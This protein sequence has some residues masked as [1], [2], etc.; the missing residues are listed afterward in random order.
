MTMLHDISTRFIQEDKP[1]DLFEQ[2]V[3]AA[4]HIVDGEMGNIQVLDAT[5]GQLRL[6]ACCS[7]GMAIPACCRQADKSQAACGLALRQA[8]RLVVDDVAA[9]VV[10]SATPWRDALLAAGVNAL[11]ATPLFTRAGKLVGMLSTHSRRR[12]ALGAHEQRL[13]DMLARQIA[14]IIERSL[15][16]AAL[17][18]SVDR[19]RS[20]FDNMLEG[21]VHGRMIFADGMPIDFEYLAVNPAFERLT[22]LREVVGRRVS[23]VLPGIRQDNPEV[24]E[25]YGRV[26]QTGEPARFETYVVAMGYWSSIAVYRPAVGEFVVVFDN[27]TERKRSAAAL[28]AREERLQL[29]KRAA[30]LGIYD[31]DVLSNAFQWDE[32]VRELWGVA[33]DEPVTFETFMAGVHADDRAATQAALDRA[34]E[35]AG[36]GQ[37]YAE[38]RVV[39]RR[40]GRER[41]VAS[42]GQ[43]YCDGGRPVRRIGMVRDIT[44]K[45]RLE[46]E[47]QA[48]REE[49]EALLQHQIATQTAAAIAHQL[50]QPLVAISAY[51]EVAAHALQSGIGG[52]EKLVRALQGCVD[53]AQRAGHTLH[54]LLDF[55]HHGDT[56]SLPMDL[57]DAVREAISLAEEGGYGGYDG[58]RLVLDLDSR[59]PLVLGNRIQIQKVVDNLLHN[60]ID[61]MREA[62]VTHPAIGIRVRHLAE[63]RLAQVTVRD[64]GPGLAAEAGSR[65][66]EP[67]FT[68]KANG[69]GLGLAISRDL[70]EA[71]GGELWSDPTA[72]PGATFHFTLPVAL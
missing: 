55:L 38:Y 71:H 43:V 11:Q 39:N 53:Q 62:G 3:R 8:E 41:H 65:A 12:G 36:N 40:D 31:E 34:F 47:L 13:L 70:I 68:T 7:L 56:V 16:T 24:F 33:A 72:S 52:N 58:L 27:I 30:G 67:F 63:R 32:R 61:A 57:N 59:L 49:M 44:E 69:I 29:A 9:S 20:L 22:G 4:L 18:E 1:K 15:A 37:F 21:C 5:S 26:A 54:E 51:S 45:K 50:N 6:A 23:E 42:T 35:P 17:Q 66:F 28:Q 2:I 25:I 60:G 10:L 64:E 19:R 14:D 46:K 48:R